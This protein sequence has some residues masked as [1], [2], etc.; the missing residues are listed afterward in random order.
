[1]QVLAC[2]FEMEPTLLDAAVISALGG[3]QSKAGKFVGGAM[4]HMDTP[5][6]TSITKLG[7]ID[8]D[9]MT[10]ILFIPPASPAAKL[11]LGVVTL[12]GTMR[13][14]SSKNS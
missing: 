10:S 4:F 14:C 2:Y 8:N 1:M 7:K 11:T 13:V 6:A 3:F 9:S 12:N 5:I